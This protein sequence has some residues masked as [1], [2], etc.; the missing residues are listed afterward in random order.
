MEDTRLH[1][2]TLY[3]WLNNSSPAKILRNFILATSV[4][5]LSL[6]SNVQFSQLHV[7]IKVGTANILHHYSCAV[8]N[9][10]NLSVFFQRFHS[11]LRHTVL[12]ADVTLTPVGDIT[13]WN[14]LNDITTGHHFTMNVI[15]ETKCHCFHFIQRNFSM[16]LAHDLCYWTGSWRSMKIF[17]IIKQG[18]VI[19]V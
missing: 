13:P 6:P 18:P 16:T 17:R 2:I 10:F 5:H 3:L 11:G 1:L 9:T 19:G 4:F 12:N 15:L 8:F 14:L 7:Y